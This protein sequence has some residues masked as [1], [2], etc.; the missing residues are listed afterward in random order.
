MLCYTR[1]VGVV[2]LKLRGLGL[3]DVLTS[4]IFAAFSVSDDALFLMDSKAVSDIKA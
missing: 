1:L 2:I 4:S 3:N